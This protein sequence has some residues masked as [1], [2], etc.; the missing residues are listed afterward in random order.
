[1]KTIDAVKLAIQQAKEKKEN[2]IQAHHNGIISDPTFLSKMTEYEAII[3]ALSWVVDEEE[4][5]DAEADIL[6][7]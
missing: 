6:V 7:K 5:W 2:H 4:N 3:Q 1:M